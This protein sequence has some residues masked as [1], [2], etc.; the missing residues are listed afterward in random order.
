[1]NQYRPAGTSGSKDSPQ[2]SKLQPGEMG[3]NTSQSRSQPTLQPSA[4]DLARPVQDMGSEASTVAASLAADVKEAA[5][6]A[7]RAVKEQASEFAADVGHELGKSAEAQKVRGVEALKG[8]AQAIDKA[9]GELE[10]QSPQVARYVRDAAQ[11]VEGLSSNI[12]GRNVAEL[13]QAASDLAR[14][15][16]ALFVGGAV[17]AGFALS[18]FLKSSAKEQRSDFST[19]ADS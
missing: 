19:T 7:T 5:R 8:F 4:E 14:S 11:K 15:H 9:A 12:G 3:G 18:R 13:M 17:A 2:S 16:P 10:G 6:T 1:M